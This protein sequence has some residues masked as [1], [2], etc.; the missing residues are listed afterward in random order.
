MT[1]VAEYERS[2]FG[3]E[4]IHNKINIDYRS[5]IEKEGVFVSQ[6]YVDNEQ[7]W[8]IYYL[9]SLD[10]FVKSI[11]DKRDKHLSVEKTHDLLDETYR[12]KLN[13][14]TTNTQ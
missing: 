12:K 9:P 2:D 14:N 13:L 4:I 8:N 11:S 6:T 10:I 7:Y 5:L 3:S 1:E